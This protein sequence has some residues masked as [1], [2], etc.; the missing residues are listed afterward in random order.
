MRPVDNDDGGPDTHGA[1]PG[2]GEEGDERVARPAREW[3]G[4]ADHLRGIAIIAV[5]IIHSTGFFR[6]S[7]MPD[8]LFEGTLTVNALARFAVPLFIFVSGLVLSTRYWGRYDREA[9]YVKRGLNVVPQYLLWSVLYIGLYAALG[10]NPDDTGP[11]ASLANG[12]A[13]PQMWFFIIIMQLY[14]LYP[15]IAGVYGSYERRGKELQL[16][17]LALAVQVVW[18][19]VGYL[20]IGLTNDGRVAFIVNRAFFTHVFYFVLGIYFARNLT[21]LKERLRGAWKWTLALGPMAVVV[22]IAHHWTTSLEIDSDVLSFF[23]VGLGRGFGTL[24]YALLIVLC[25]LASGHL[26]KATS[27]LTK[28]LGSYSYGIYLIHIVFLEVVILAL[29]GQGLSFGDWVLYPV[30]FLGTLLLSYIAVKGLSMVPSAWIVLGKGAWTVRSDGDIA[31]P[32]A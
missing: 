9:F 18:Y 27:R 4:E 8:W 29:E 7:E 16:L 11:L 21:T 6:E 25:F 22:A 31:P 23:Y 28:E 12:T 24:Y 3:I 5:V 32:K 1:E 2:A 20:C 26:A 30:L 14:V 17:A 10:G 15:I 19:V 13:A